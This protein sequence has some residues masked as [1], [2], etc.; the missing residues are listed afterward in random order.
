MADHVLSL[1]DKQERSAGRIVAALN[2]ALGANNPTPLTV[3]AWMRDTIL[4][5]IK[6]ELAMRDAEKVAPIV[7]VLP[8][9]TNAQ[10]TQIKTILGI[11]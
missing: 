5:P 6:A 3:D 10:L 7:A 8:D 4:Q 11:S 9:A 1:N 2:N